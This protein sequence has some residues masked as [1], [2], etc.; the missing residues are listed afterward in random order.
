LTVPVL[1][2]PFERANWG[3]GVSDEVLSTSKAKA[4]REWNIQRGQDRRVNV[5]N[6]EDF[7]EKDFGRLLTNELEL[8]EPKKII[9]LDGAAGASGETRVITSISPLSIENDEMVTVSYY[10]SSP[11]NGDWVGAYSPPDVDI[12]T[13]VPVKYAWMDHDPKYM[14]TK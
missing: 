14:K 5:E 11:D 2:N 8:I 10:S 13:T 9:R 4:R 3:S 12:S 1:S 6:E 7:V